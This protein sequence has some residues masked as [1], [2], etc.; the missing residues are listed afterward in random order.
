MGS[1][2]GKDCL[3]PLLTRH[4]ERLLIG[5][6]SSNK[7]IILKEANP[8]LDHA[9]FDKQDYTKGQQHGSCHWIC[10]MAASDDELRSDLA[11]CIVNRTIGKAIVEYF[12]GG[13]IFY[14]RM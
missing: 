13:L 8:I 14:H 2:K 6:H 4:L 11:S 1:D 5:I 10:L 7:G 3:I 9:D 12:G